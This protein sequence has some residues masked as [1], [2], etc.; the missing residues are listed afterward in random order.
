MVFFWIFEVFPLYVTAL[1]PLVMFPLSGVNSIQVI[2]QSYGSPIVFLFLGGFALAAG[3][4][5]WRI[6]ERVAFKILALSG[7][8]PRKV[9]AGIIISTAIISMWISNTAT[10]LMMLPVVISISEIYKKFSPQTSQNFSTAL[11]LGLA[12]SASVGGVSTIIGTPPNVVLLGLFEK[13]YKKSIDFVAWLPIGLTFSILFCFFIFFFLNRWYGL[14]KE[15]IEEIST[16]IQEKNNHFAPLQK[17]EIRLLLVFIF[18]VCLW[19]FKNPIN[20]I[21]QGNYLTDHITAMIGFILL[22]IVPSG[23]TNQSRLLVWDDIQRIP[24]GILLLFGGGLAL[25]GQ[26]EEVGIIEYIGNYISKIFESG[27]TAL[28]VLILVFLTIIL[29]EIMSNVALINVF[30][31]IVFAIAEGL[32]IHP[33]QAAI[34]VTIAASCAFMMPISTPP[35]AIVYSAG[36]FKAGEMFR[37]GFFLNIIAI[38]A[39][40]LLSFVLPVPN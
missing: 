9:L 18:I 39:I 24:W 34:P 2:S 17:S 27:N 40:W 7:S 29:T 22:F 10:A 1:L 31:P 6:H 21:F 36:L 13:Y 30:I 15:N 28:L 23:K 37:V 16:F 20:L 12:Y 19:I 32:H 11:L 33:L 8:S 26:L 38:I 4:E 25:A 5:K 14:K 3:L 35:N